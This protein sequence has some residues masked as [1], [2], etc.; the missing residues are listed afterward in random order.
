MTTTLLPG[1]LRTVARNV[2]R[3]HQRPRPV[4]DGTGDAAALGRRSRRSCRS[5]AA[6]PRG[7]GTTST[8]RSPTSRCTSPSPSAATATAPAGGARDGRA[9]WSDAIEAVRDVA[10]ALGARAD[11][12]SGAPRRPWHPGRCAELAAR[13]DRRSATPASCTPRCAGPSASRRAP[14]SPRS[15]STRCWPTPSRCRA[16]PSFSTYPVAK[17]DVALV[18]A[19]DLPGRRARATTLREGAGPL[20]E[21]VRLFDVYTG[22]AGRRGP[23]V[24]GLRAALPGTGPDAH[25]GGHGGRP[26]RGGRAGRPAARGRRSAPEPVRALLR[27]L[28][29]RPA[30][31]R[32]GDPGR[33]PCRGQASSTAAAPMPAR[34][35]YRRRGRSQRRDV[36]PE[37]CRSSGG[38]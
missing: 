11:R 25:R 32:R 8:R 6:R 1:L 4:R 34:S 23:Q 15:T 24:A 26:R 29:A 38:R 17:E 7:S 13:R 18:V 27:P 35:R 30:G 21:S 9:A 20:C 22:A 5:T 33:R 16:A 10:G 14:R 19:A 2:G 31:S 3:G 37:Q 28:S 36:L 12:A